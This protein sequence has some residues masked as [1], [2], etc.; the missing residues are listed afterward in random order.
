[1]H[2]FNSKLISLWASLVAQTV[3][4]LPTMWET[5][6]RSLGQEDPLEK[7]MA[8]Y[9]SI[10]AWRIQWTEESGRLQSTGSQRVRH[11]WETSLSLSLYGPADYAKWLWN[12]YCTQ[13]NKGT[14]SMPDFFL[15]I[16]ERPNSFKLCRTS[17]LTR[18]KSKE[19]EPLLIPTTERWNPASCLSR[20]L[21]A[22]RHQ[23][24]LLLALGGQVEQ[25]LPFP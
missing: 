21:R 11:D 10:L 12:S 25:T 19:T 3:K 20:T 6:V 13:R 18:R 5:Q 1:M 23:G 16:L 4:H 14:K 8:T 22:G 2:L 24:P 7:E 15:L 17:G 9:S